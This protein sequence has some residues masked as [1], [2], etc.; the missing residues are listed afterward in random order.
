VSDNWKYRRCS[1]CHSK[2]LLYQARLKTIRK[3]DRD[4][5]L[6][7]SLRAKYPQSKTFRDF[8]VWFRSIW[9]RNPTFDEF[10][11]FKEELHNRETQEKAKI[12]TVNTRREMNLEKA[13]NEIKFPLVSEDCKTYRLSRMK[14]Q[15]SFE[16]SVN[17]THT[18]QCSSCTAWLDWF[19]HDYEEKREGKEGDMSPF[20]SLNLGA[21][22]WKG[23]SE[24]ESPYT[25]KPLDKELNRKDFDDR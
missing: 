16:E 13:I 8:T 10:L 15:R 24:T 18:Y 5:S 20:D 17:M 4:N 19:K 7:S 25:S 6:S 9:K 1:S 12:E 22:F 21:N 11:K 14:N 23:E 3:L 2:D